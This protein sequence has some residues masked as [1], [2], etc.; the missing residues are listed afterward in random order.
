MDTDDVLNNEINSKSGEEKEDAF[1]NVEFSKTKLD[2]RR[3]LELLLEEAKL[4][5]ELSDDEY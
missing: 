1:S 3:R 2:A 5:K 4:L